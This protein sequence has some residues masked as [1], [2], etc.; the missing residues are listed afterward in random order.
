M[1]AKGWGNT[2]I[3]ER[4][5]AIPHSTPQAHRWHLL[6]THLNGHMSADRLRK[7]GIESADDTCALCRVEPDTYMH[8]QECPIIRQARAEVP[9]MQIAPPLARVAYTFM[10]ID[11][12][13]GEAFGGNVGIRLGLFQRKSL[14][15]CRIILCAR[16]ILSFIM[17]PLM[18]IFS[19]S[20]L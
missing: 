8:L 4:L 18:S 16:I 3:A 5:R 2:Q 10:L 9:M 13:D 19:F 11:R 15:C 6:R 20:F 1:Q 14:V 7:A 12:V 17:F